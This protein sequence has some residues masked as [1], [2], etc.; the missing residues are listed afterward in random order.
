MEESLVKSQGS[1]SFTG[2]LSIG[3]AGGSF[4]ICYFTERWPKDQAVLLIPAF[5]ACRTK[6][7]FKR[8]TKYHSGEC[9]RKNIDFVF[10]W[11]LADS[12]FG[13]V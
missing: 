7:G 12:L 5:A 2:V 6:T 13:I 11:N 9:L 4:V 1:Y 8:Q 3:C 10:T